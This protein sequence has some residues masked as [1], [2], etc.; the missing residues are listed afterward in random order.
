MPYRK[1]SSDDLQTEFDFV[2]LEDLALH[3]FSV[4]CG[5]LQSLEKKYQTRH[6]PCGKYGKYPCRERGFRSPS[7]IQLQ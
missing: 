4:E 2:E 6:Y 1:Y 5:S 7:S 3:V